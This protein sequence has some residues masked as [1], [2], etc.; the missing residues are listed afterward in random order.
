MATVLGL[1][2][3]IGSGKSSVARLLAD[4]GAVVIDADAIVHE[5]Q[6][7]G[8]PM[9]DEIAQAFGTHLVR[10]DGSLD[11]E[12]L[13]NIVFRD[14]AARERLGRI[15]HPGVRREMAARLEEARTSDA[16]LILLDIP[17]LFEGAAAGAD[18]RAVFGVDTTVLVWVPQDVQI[19]RTVARDGCSRD[20]A[21]RRVAAQMP[22]ED[23]RPLADHVLDNSGSRSETEAAVAALFPTLCQSD[24]LS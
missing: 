14:E 5:L 12:A 10:E 13:G 8:T 23:K 11:R 21:E 20:E 9:V 18:T 15:V 7:P 6:A 16:P 3:G 22:L 17:L 1:T 19:D 24:K 4:R 2:G